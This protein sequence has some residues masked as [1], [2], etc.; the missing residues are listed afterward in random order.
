MV[1]SVVYGR[2]AVAGRARKTVLVG[3]DM[4]EATL[5]YQRKV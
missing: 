4:P 2:E 3:G 5:D 1:F